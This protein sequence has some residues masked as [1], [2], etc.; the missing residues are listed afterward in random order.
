MHSGRGM[1]EA[2]FRDPNSG[3]PD[4]KPRKAPSLAHR[5]LAWGHPK[6]NQVG[7]ERWVVLG[8]QFQRRILV[9]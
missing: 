7:R 6:P 1:D 8:L 2:V 3:L 5:K 9:F 4:P